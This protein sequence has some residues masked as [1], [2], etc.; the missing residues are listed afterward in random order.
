MKENNPCSFHVY[1]HVSQHTVAE[2]DSAIVCFV[3]SWS[4]AGARN[5]QSGVDVD[6]D[7]HNQVENGP[8]DAQHG[9][10]GLLLTLLVLDSLFLIT[11]DSVYHF[12]WKNLQFSSH[13]LEKAEIYSQTLLVLVNA[14]FSCCCCFFPSKW[15]LHGAWWPALMVMNQQEDLWMKRSLTQLNNYAACAAALNWLRLCSGWLEVV[16]IFTPMNGRKCDWS[17]QR[18]K[19]FLLLQRM[20]MW[21]RSEGGGGEEGLKQY[22]CYSADL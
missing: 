8:N 20:W 2:L 13:N 10:D 5:L 3:C 22:H 11:V 6:K 19:L 14:A 12:P 17:E 4:L 1:L 9:Q 15:V 21:G 16:G 7:D 18:G